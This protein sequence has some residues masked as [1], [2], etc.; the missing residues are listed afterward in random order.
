MRNSVLHCAETS[1]LEPSLQFRKK[2][3]DDA[4][5]GQYGGGEIIIKFVKDKITS[6]SEMCL[7][8]HCRDFKKMTSQSTYK[9]VFRIIYELLFMQ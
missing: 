8:M 1:S 5:S 6:Q 2:K 4:K 7:L 9:N 3:S